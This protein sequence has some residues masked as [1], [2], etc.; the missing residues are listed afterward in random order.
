ML[1]IKDMRFDDKLKVWIEARALANQLFPYLGGSVLRYNDYSHIGILRIKK[2][3]LKAKQIID[4][5]EH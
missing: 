4:D 2:N 3:L 1:Y 5:F